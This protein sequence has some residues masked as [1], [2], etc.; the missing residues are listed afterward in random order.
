MQLIQNG[1]IVTMEG[2][3]YQNG[4]ILIKDGKIVQIGGMDELPTGEY[5][6]I[7]DAQGGWVLPGFVDAHCHVGMFG[8]GGGAEGDDGNEDTDPVMPQLRAIDAVNPFDEAFAN[9]RNAGVTTV[10]TGPGSA[11]VFAG[12]FAALKTAGVCVDDMVI[13]APVAQ[14]VA[15]GENPKAVYGE[16]NQ[17][18]VTRMA[19]AALVRETL[20]RALRYF[21]QQEGYRR[22]PE[23]CDEPDLDFKLESLLPVVRGEIPLKIH[24]HRADDI[25]TAIRLGREFGVKVTLEHC[26]EGHLVAEH[27]RAAGVPVMLGPTL[28]NKSKPELRNLSFDTARVLCGAGIPAAIITDHPEVPIEYLPLC[29]ALCVRHGLDRREALRAITINA[30]RNT[31]IAHRVGS[32]APGK[33]ADIVV[34][35]CDPLL[36]DSHVQLVLIDGVQVNGERL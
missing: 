36:L 6:E 5:E 12:Q 11:N 34:F 3:D 35:D 32:L 1:Y 29:A 4:Y 26:T 8:E 24:A 2:Q 17:T 21:R 10:V 14:K 16:R 18:P 30:A 25:L 7:Y 15:L 27:I 20:A 13:K 22:D 28:G 31:G 23:G 19:T 33:D 9:A